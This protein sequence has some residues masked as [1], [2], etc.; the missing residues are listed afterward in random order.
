[1]PTVA[2]TSSTV[3]VSKPLM[4]SKRLVASTMASSRAW[5]ICA[6]N[7]GL[8]CDS[9]FMRPMLARAR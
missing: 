7:E 8:G 5:C 9:M 4:P 2:A 3:M 1:M 6:L